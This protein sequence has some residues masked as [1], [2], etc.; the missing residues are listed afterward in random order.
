MKRLLL[1]FALSLPIFAKAQTNALPLPIDMHFVYLTLYGQSCNYGVNLIENQGQSGG[2]PGVIYYEEQF[3]SMYCPVNDF[4]CTPNY[5]QQ[6][7]SQVGNKW[8]KGDYLWFDWDNQVGDS[9]QLDYL[10]NLVDCIVTNIDTIIFADFIPRRQYHLIS[11]D[12]Y[13]LSL[14][15]QTITFI[16]GIGTNILGL[17][18]HG[19][20]SNQ[21]LS[22]VFDNNGLQ[23]MQ[24]DFHPDMIGCCNPI[25][26][27]ET[28]TSS[29]KLFPSPASDQTSLQ[30]EAAHIPQ[31]IQIFNATGQLMHTEN[32]LGR[33]QMQVNVSDFAKG[34]Y[35]VRG[36]FENGEEVSEKL[37]VE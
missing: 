28:A 34:V 32:V 7:M 18:S 27:E 12:G 4:Y 9:C 6:S 26:V 5:W 31:T 37:V 1:L 17:E 2:L 23:I 10:G 21:Y 25:S 29:F 8:F 15:G 30:F 33:L 20:E 11:P 13:E 35:T 3:N 16:E 14:F 24:N 19:V 36:R 22:C